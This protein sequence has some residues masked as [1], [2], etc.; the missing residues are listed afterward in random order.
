MVTAGFERDVDGRAAHSIAGLSQCA[1][2]SMALA[3]SLVP[4]LARNLAIRC[5]NDAANVG[6][7]IGRVDATL[8]QPQGARHVFVIDGQK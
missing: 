4:T 3:C 6:I 7:R 1:H 2:F 5:N 8:R